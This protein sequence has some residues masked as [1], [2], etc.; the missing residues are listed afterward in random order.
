M[1]GQVQA[2]LGDAARALL[3]GRLPEAG[4][5]YAACAGEVPGL[6]ALGGALVAW[7]RGEFEALGRLAGEASEGPRGVVWA[8]EGLAAVRAGR[9]REG[10]ARQVAGLEEARRG[11]EGA[12]LNASL[13]IADSLI[14]LGRLD[15]A[16]A[17]LAGV[18]EALGDGAPLAALLVARYEMALG[19]RVPDVAL[20]RRAGD[21]VGLVWALRWSGAFEEALEMARGL[22]MQL[23]AGECLAGLGRFEEAAMHAR[24]AGC[25][26]SEATWRGDSPRLEAIAAGLDEAERAAFWSV[27]G[28]KR[29]AAALDVAALERLAT[30]LAEISA[31]GGPREAMQVALAHFVATARAERGFLLRLAGFEVL[32]KVIHGAAPD[33]YSTSLADRVVWSGEPLVV[34]DLTADAELGAAASV[35]ALGLRTALGLPL[36]A[37]GEVVGVML[38]DS[39][40]V[41]PG[42][43]PVDLAIAR[44]IAAHVVGG[45]GVWERA[46]SGGP[47]GG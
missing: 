29:G 38:A 5:R 17:T 31:A 15:E 3:G 22:G 7:A 40:Q 23:M 14:H 18:R 37:A 6:A 20:A 4:M 9:V 10:L 27:P 11:G 28:R 16:R 19:D 43:T 41:H 8:L 25:V 33:A 26:V 36:L 35:Q 32:D 2:M 13:A 44:A 24:A 21:A 1:Q 34:E 47:V 39:R 30:L 12:A 45:R 46:A 42:F